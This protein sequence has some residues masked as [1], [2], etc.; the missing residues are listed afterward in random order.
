MNILKND[1]EY[2]DKK[3]KKVVSISKEYGYSELNEEFW[4][5]Q[6]AIVMSLIV[7]MDDNSLRI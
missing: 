4:K 1:V 3:V 2:W 5:R 7:K 6:P